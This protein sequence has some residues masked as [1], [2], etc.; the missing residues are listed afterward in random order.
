MDNLV[1]HHT[2][3][4]LDLLGVLLG[5][6][7]LLGNKLLHVLYLILQ[8]CSLGLTRLELLVSLMQLGLE[9]V[10]VALGGDQFVL[11]VLQLGAGVIKEVGLEVTTAISRHQLVIQLL[12]T[13]LKVGVLLEKLSV[14]G[15]TKILA[16]NG[17]RARIEPYDA[18]SSAAAHGASSQVTSQSSSSPLG[19]TNLPQQPQY[20][21]ISTH[22]YDPTSKV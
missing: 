17:T 22:K 18:K 4:A 9:V 14:E 13:Y 20:S 8:F 19:H 1:V 11:S 16:L 10:D 7:R 5:L 15:K 12:D 3:H 2:K 21:G 6:L